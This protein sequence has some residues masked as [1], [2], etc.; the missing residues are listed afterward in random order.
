MRPWRR[1]LGRRRGAA[2]R[3]AAASDRDGDDVAREEVRIARASL[4]PALR[5]RRG[6]DCRLAAAPR[7]PAAKPTSTDNSVPRD[8]RQH[9]QPDVALASGPR[10]GGRRAR[11]RPVYQRPSSSAAAARIARPGD[12][13]RE[14]ER[15][16]ARRRRA[17]ARCSRSAAA[18]RARSAGSRASQ[19]PSS[20]SPVAVVASPN[21]ARLGD[22]TQPDPCRGG[23]REV[24]RATGRR[25]P[26]APARRRPLSRRSR[27]R[28]PP[29]RR[30]AAAAAAACA[31]R[32]PYR[33]AARERWRGCHGCAPSTRP[34]DAAGQGECNE[35]HAGDAHAA[36]DAVGLRLIRGRPRA[37]P[38]LDGDPGAAARPGEFGLVALALV[39]TALLESVSD[40]GV[41]QALVVSRGDEAVERRR[42][43]TA[44]AISVVPR[45]RC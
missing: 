35:S 26:R 9:D 2:G 36:R 23:D 11:R 13:E 5:A 30:S 16:A 39:F 7:P 12:R 24:D 21:G 27:P 34:A 41:G 19:A 17:A 33:P 22:E 14:P 25:P 42:A 3:A 15:A 4:Q 37:G 10:S 38:R 40:L 28:R 20:R 32:R 29:R 18:T 6:V 45:R 44:F 8:Q 31:C 1:P 43:E